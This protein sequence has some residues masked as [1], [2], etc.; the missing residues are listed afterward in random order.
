ME[1]RVLQT[2]ENALLPSLLRA[3]ADLRRT[4][5]ESAI[6]L[7]R[8]AGTSLLRPLRGAELSAV[9]S[10][11][12]TLRLQYPKEDLGF[13]YASGALRHEGAGGGTPAPP[14]MVCPVIN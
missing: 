10:S 4:A 2:T 7:G 13:A 11:G 8:A 1:E 6:S 14:W 5:L 3:P 12:E 9:F